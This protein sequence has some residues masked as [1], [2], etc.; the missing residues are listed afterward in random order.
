MNPLEKDFQWLAYE[1]H[2]GLLPWLHGAHLQLAN[3][4]I[5]P[6]SAKKYDL[7]MHCLKLAV[8]EGRSLI[9]FLEGLESCQRVSLEERLQHLVM[10]AQPMAHE[11]AQQLSLQGTLGEAQMLPAASCWSILRIVQQAVHNALQHAGP[12]EIRIL[13][14]HTGSEMLI[15]IVDQGRG[16]DSKAL[17]EEGH[18]GLASMRQRSLAVAGQLV[19]TSL[20][21]QG[22]QVCLTVPTR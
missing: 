17:Q 4:S 21:G 10:N 20:P 3:L 12:T 22:T 19:I 9:G 6:E 5:H 14:S 2:D 15:Q 8:E 18:F 13:L 1:L 16:F 11:R 7:A